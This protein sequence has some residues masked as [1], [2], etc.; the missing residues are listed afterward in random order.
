M[1]LN[2]KSIQTWLADYA[3]QLKKLRADIEDLEVQREDVLFAPPAQADVQAALASWVESQRSTYQ[4][5]LKKNL[6]N[7]AT[8]R[9]LIE[10]PE[11]VSRFMVAAP[12]MR[13]ASTAGGF[14]NRDNDQAICGLFGD[15]IIKSISTTL[16]QL[17]WTKDGMSAADRVRRLVEL[18]KKLETLRAEERSFVAAAA[19]TGISVEA[20]E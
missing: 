11:M 6:T 8:N 15:A 4:D 1:A 3:G 17:D 5:A 16:S 18:D 10:T 13:P 2:F 20:V 7:L 12:F 19:D 9:H 14:H